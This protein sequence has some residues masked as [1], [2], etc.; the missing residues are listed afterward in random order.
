M[1]SSTATTADHTWKD[2]F[3]NSEFSFCESKNDLILPDK[4]LKVLSGVLIFASMV[5]SHGKNVISVMKLACHKAFYP[6]GGSFIRGCYR[7]ARLGI[8]V[9]LPHG[10]VRLSWEYGDSSSRLVL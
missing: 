5:S 7:T 4:F 9:A 8:R 2:R 3:R 1:K 10:I 6:R